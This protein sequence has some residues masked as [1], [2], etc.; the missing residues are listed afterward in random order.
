MKSE[1]PAGWRQ[2]RLGD[3]IEVHHGFAFRGEFFRAEPPGDLLLTPGN[4]SIGGGFSW[5]KR[6]YYDGPVDERFVLRDGALLITMTDLSRNS[7]TLG[8][9]AIVPQVLMAPAS[10]TTSVLAVW[11]S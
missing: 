11:K 7:D 6:K 4:F 3:L 1:L 8:S 10:C 9:P 5:A 2:A